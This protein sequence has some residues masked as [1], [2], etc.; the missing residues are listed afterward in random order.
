M[1]RK[2]PSFLDK[3]QTDLS[4][5]IRALQCAWRETAQYPAEEISELI[6]HRHLLR[7]IAL[8]Q[9]W[10]NADEQERLSFEQHMEDFIT[11]LYGTGEPFIFLFF[12]Q[13]E[14]IKVLIGLK[15]FERDVE[16]LSSQLK[17]SF[18]GI[19]LDKG[20]LSE[21]PAFS[22]SGG[23]TGIPSSKKTT[24]DQPEAEQI[25]R[26][27]HGLYGDLWAYLVEAQ[28]I[29]MEDV[30]L[31]SDAIAKE[32]RNTYKTRLLPGTPNEKDR[33]ASHYVELLEAQF[34]RLSLAQ[35]VGAWQVK[36]L[37]FAE[38]ESTLRRG[39][40]L[41]KGI[42]SGDESFPEPI[43]TFVAT[44]GVSTTKSN[45][46]DDPRI[47]LITSRE[48]ALLAQLP[49]EEFPGY[50]VQPFS[51]F[52]ASFTPLEGERIAVGKI[53]FEGA[54]TENTLSVSLNE[55]C[56]HGLIAG[57][58]GSGKTNTIFHLL[59]QLWREHRISFLV[60]EPAKREYRNLLN[61]EGFE[62]LQ[63]FTLGD[64]TAVPFRLNPFEAPEGISIQTHIDLLLSAF[65]A[66]FVLYAPMP[67]V[68]EQSIYEVYYDRGW[69]LASNLNARGTGPASFPTLSG[70]YFKV[71]E[72]I[73]RLGYDEKIKNDLK[74]ALRV[75]INSLRIGGKGLMLDTRKS[76]EIESIMKRPTVLEL[77]AIGSDQEKA[78]VMGLLLTILY[79]YWESQPKCKKNTLQHLTVVEEAHRLL[80]NVTESQHPEAV[81]TQA[82]AVE[83]FCNILSEIRAYGEGVVIADQI[84]VKLAP[85]AIK[86]TNLKVM[87]RMVAQEDREVMGGAMNLSEEQ[88]RTVVS[89]NCGKAAVFAEGMDGP[90]L[91]K[92]PNVK[93]SLESNGNV[94]KDAVKAHMDTIF[95][96]TYPSTRQR[97]N[98][99]LE[100]D[101]STN[102]D[103]FRTA[104]SLLLADFD[105]RKSFSRLFLTALLDSSHLEDALSGT[106][107]TMREFLV[108]LSKKGQDTQLYCA[109]L[110][111][112]EHNLDAKGALYRWNFDTVEE[113]FELF[114]KICLQISK[115]GI[116]SGLDSL[117]EGFSRKYYSLCQS[118]AGPFI[119]CAY[120]EKRCRYLYEIDLLIKDEQL[121][122]DFCMGIR[123]GGDSE[124]IWRSVYKTCQKA[125]KAAVCTSHSEIS[126]PLALCFAVQKVAQLRFPS[127]EQHK[128]VKKMLA[129]FNLN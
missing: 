101:A 3:S 88:K 38:E 67:Y 43:R 73:D 75:R 102:C 123:S 40:A 111:A 82:K 58:T 74:A 65:N 44:T 117:I 69:N 46:S 25:E 99:C 93:E 31:Q 27:I 124:E 47:M 53:L 113:F 28:P 9:F 37:L 94:E 59:S 18:P 24:E 103:N 60:I 78:F 66:S 49:K 41:L 1:R 36:A 118:E 110:H 29:S 63:V 21:I 112:L 61:V 107:Q 128:L 79:E 86:N 95:Y 64:E 96:S 57:V 84:P 50:V 76:I 10:L 92:V 51:R 72:V 71:E 91:V 15:E 80:K 23:L 16:L 30:L 12:C 56:K 98:A 114:S 4:E 116:Q 55:L 127:E 7:L 104:S 68:L 85:D 105:F 121:H 5:E 129:L 119:G 48:L 106:I 120:C 109:L 11:S 122:R 45:V 125:A 52:N 22:F 77:A 100:C 14:Q 108:M 32:I 97:F 17:A 89:L 126:T 13:R 81:T 62:E 42:Y 54:Q 20:E 70:L 39:L 2:L 87:H 90:F 6:P 26:L 83:A 115:M 34:E 19:E 35:Q 33:V 8:S